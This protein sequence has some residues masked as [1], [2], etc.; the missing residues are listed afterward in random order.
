[1]PRKNYLANVVLFGYLSIKKLIEAYIDKAKLILFYQRAEVIRCF[2]DPDVTPG[3]R[4]K[5]LVTIAHITSKE[6]SSDRHKATLKIER[7]KNTID[8]LLTSFAHCD[9]QILLYTVPGQHITAYLPSYQRQRITVQEVPDCDP[10]YIGFQAQDGLAARVNHFDWFIFIEDDIVIYDS[11]FLEKI[12]AFC[13]QSPRPNALLFP[14]RYEMYDGKKSY[15]DLTVVSEPVWDKVSSFEI[16]GVKFSEFVN[17]HSGMY[18]LSQ[19][20]MQHWIHSGRNWKNRD[21][22]V[23]PLESA[24]TFC[25]FECFTVYKP[26][27]KN[28][29]YLEIRHFDTKYSKLFSEPS[30]YIISAVPEVATCGSYV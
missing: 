2:A 19:T 5:V 13:R 16:N 25:L 29:N 27:P 24:A 3:Q 14:N 10:M 26:H 30:P 20:Q 17:P 18:C 9:L 11:L 28:L 4:F 7:L 15:I 6:E 12:D 1:M 23:G 21:I 8:G 22:M